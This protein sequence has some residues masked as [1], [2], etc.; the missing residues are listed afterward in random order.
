MTNPIA[1]ANTDI[2]K[3]EQ[4]DKTSTILTMIRRGDTISQIS[5]MLNVKRHDVEKLMDWYVEEMMA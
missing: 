3:A 2:R 4:E 5:S 1:S